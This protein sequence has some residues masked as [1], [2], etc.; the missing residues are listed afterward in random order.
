MAVKFSI[1]QPDAAD[2]VYLAEH[3][4]QSDQ[5][6]LEAVGFS[7]PLAALKLSVSL[8][9]VDYLKLICVDG[10]PLCIFGVVSRCLLSSEAEIWMLATNELYRYPKRLTLHS[11]LMV[12]IMLKRW[13]KLYNVID[14]RSQLTIRWL[15][16]IGFTMTETIEVKP[17]YPVF[18]FEI[19]AHEQNRSPVSSSH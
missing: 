3:L 10:V 15:Q 17:G 1:K 2:L 14:V 5:L 13:R 11:K 12:R 4:R 7:D 16:L 6:E 18:R 9:D 19:N 8:S